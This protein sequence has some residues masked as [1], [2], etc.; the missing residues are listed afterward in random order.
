MGESCENELFYGN[1]FCGILTPS[2]YRITGPFDGSVFSDVSYGESKLCPALF[3]DQAV[4]DH[5]S[6]T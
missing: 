5:A 3:K 6:L 1:I 4:T 2:A